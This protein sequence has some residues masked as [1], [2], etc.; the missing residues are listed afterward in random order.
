MMM[1]DAIFLFCLFCLQS[2]QGCPELPRVSGIVE[3]A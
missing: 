2:V 3:V 1:G